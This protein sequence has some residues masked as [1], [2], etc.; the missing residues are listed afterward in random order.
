MKSTGIVR[1][2]DGL[3]RIVLPK[4]LRTSMK[5]TTDAKL[6]IFVDGENIILKKY[7]PVGSCDFCGEVDP[8]AV[9]YAGYCIC[10]ACRRKIGGLH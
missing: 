4:E 2:V 3:G 7:R 1:G 9:K 6:E 5:L 10:T 8:N